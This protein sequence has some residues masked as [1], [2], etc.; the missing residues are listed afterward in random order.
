MAIDKR[1]VTDLGRMISG[2][3]DLRFRPDL[4]DMANIGYDESLAAAG[5]T[6]S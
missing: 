3:E 6:V 5:S 4:C 2:I 1:A